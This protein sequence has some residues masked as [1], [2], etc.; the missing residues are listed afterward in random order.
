MNPTFILFAVD[1]AA[2]AGVTGVGG[3]LGTGHAPHGQIPRIQQ[4]V[5]HFELDTALT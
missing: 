4:G 1:P 3:G 2:G 5:M